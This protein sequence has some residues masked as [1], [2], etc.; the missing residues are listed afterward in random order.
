MVRYRV[1]LAV[2]AGVPIR[3]QG[4][5]YSYGSAICRRSALKDTDFTLT[6]VLVSMYD[7]D[8]TIQICLWQI[9]WGMIFI[10]QIYHWHIF[11][12][13][14]CFMQHWFVFEKTDIVYDFQQCRSDSECFIQYRFGFDKFFMVLVDFFIFLSHRFVNIT[15]FF[16]FFEN[17]SLSY[18]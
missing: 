6:N 14:E 10:I 13:N 12:V 8:S 7:S 1:G 2:V 17:L 4:T 15:F 3:G 9:C 18:F 16:F 11:F 5:A